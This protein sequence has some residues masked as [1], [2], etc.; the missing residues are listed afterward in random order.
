MQTGRILLFILIAY[1]L[2]SIPFGWLIAKSKGVDI[3]KTGSGNIGATNVLRTL[4]KPAGITCFALDV[5]KGLLPA[6]L[7]PRLGA[8]DP[9]F[10]ILFGAAAIL[11]HT[12]P[13]FLRFKGGKGVAT[14]A[15]VL[16]GVTPLAVLIGLA[17]WIVIFWISGYVSLGSVVAT[18]VVLLA[19]WILDY[20]TVTATAL[21]LM[22]FLS[23]F[24]HRENIRRLLNGTE[25][26]FQR[27]SR[28]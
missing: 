24:R 27:K 2:G 9:Q 21:T 4:G 14:G 12:F 18:L 11:G 20:G 1:L 15:G 25:H 28:S 13:V 26:R 3:R 5:L 6:S 22:A 17:T 23:L 16:L 10:G 8:L 19:G 7:F